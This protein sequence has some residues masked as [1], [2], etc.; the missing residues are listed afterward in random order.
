MGQAAKQSIVD[1][2][3]IEEQITALELYLLKV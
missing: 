2:F 3:L 1:R